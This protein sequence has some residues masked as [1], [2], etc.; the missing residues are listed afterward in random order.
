MSV[1]SKTMTVFVRA[2]IQN[3]AAQMGNV[4]K[5]LK[6]TLGKNG[7]DM[8][9][10]FAEGLGIAAAALGAFG[11]A[12]VKMSADFA[13]TKKA[14]NVLL[15]SSDKA[16]KHLEDLTQFAAQTPFE[17]KGLTEASKKMLAFKFDVEDVIPI[18]SAVGDAAA[19]L[20]SGQEGIDGM[21]MALSQMKAKGR[22]QGEE[23]LQLAERGVN[24]YQ[25][26]ADY[27]GTDIPGVMDKMRKG[28]VDSTTAIN[29]VVL[30]MQKDF[31][32]GMKGL[33]EEINGMVSN[34]KDGTESVMRDIGKSITEGLNIKEHLK[35]TTEVISGFA[36]AV[37]KLGIREAI[38]QMV[39]PEAIVLIGSLGAVIVTIAVPALVALAAKAL[40]A[41]LAIGGISAPV[42][43]AAAV[44][45]GAF[46]LIMATTDELGN[47]WFNTWEWMK[48]TTSTF[49]DAI[50][51]SIWNFAKDMLEYLKPIMEFF[52]MTDT[53]K[54][55]TAAVSQGVK[56]SS[57]SLNQS[58]LK[59]A[60]DSIGMDKAWAD[61][62]DKL[63]GS[64]DKIKSFNVGNSLDSTFTGLKG[65]GAD[66]EQKTLTK[67]IAKDVSKIATTTNNG[68]IAV[69]KMRALQG[70]ISY[71]AQD[72]T[73]C[74]R[75]IGMALEG[76]P[77]E[78][79]IDVDVARAIAEKEGLWRDSSY[80]AQAGDIAI[81]NDGWH[82]TMVT[83][84]GG[85]IQ[86]G[87]SHNGVWESSQSPEDMFGGVTG[88]IATSSYFT[89]ARES[90]DN[91]RA[92]TLEWEET[93]NRIN[94]SAQDLAL[95]LT[96]RNKLLGLEGVRKDYQE[97]LLE[98]DKY[99]VEL[100]RKYRDMALKFAKAS[101]PE[102]GAMMS[103]W[104]ENGIA[105]EETEKGKVSFSQ[106]IASELVLIEAE[107]QEKIK[108]LNMA[109]KLFEDDLAKARKETDLAM[110]QEVLSSEQ[111]LTELRKENARSFIDQYYDL[112]KE[113]H[114]TFSDSF[115]SGV[116]D[117]A[118]SFADFF[119]GV[120]TGSSSL[121]ESFAD[122]LSSF[123]SMVAE[124][125]AKWAAARVTMGMFQSIM[126]QNNSLLGSIISVSGG[127]LN[128][129]GGLD[130]YV[131]AGPSISIGAAAGG[132]VVSGLTLVGEEG[133]EL[134]KFNSLSRVFNNKDTKAMMGGSSINMYVSTPDAESF[135]Q[136]RA[137]ISSSLAGMVARGRRNT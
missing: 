69:D 56:L 102:Q 114:T 41:V 15:G 119:K 58:A 13:A 62:K 103:A 65:T 5:T 68:K 22:A 131:S 70:K 3:F 99:A 1:A 106:Q 108:S 71:Y 127:G 48:S 90:I 43:L 6:K 25:Y 107:K 137:Q 74:M 87:E 125:V 85:T 52:G 94:D 120:I 135:K 118:D 83:E 4:E 7:Y 31:K 78:G 76:T 93:L 27:L 20:G 17:L 49:V 86:N 91:L 14:F 47:L 128:L 129:T 61:T 44:I 80:K 67:G 109:T 133:P 111:A 16:Q 64:L 35:E 23:M 115:K 122:L 33:S 117:V 79:V 8:S 10:K 42:I 100:E 40:A 81:V 39:P 113:A 136:S 130:S 98:T 73:N 77:F 124:M 12:V 54:N 30:G 57:Q 97:L 29:A 105:F 116:G 134:V 24:A 46:A 121:K 96:E 19:M 51:L 101:V 9:R 132:G 112:W 45:G 89:G 104:T 55:W 72:G 60:A 59:N 66:S 50:S 75:T 92:K 26:L 38:L 2:N 63:S 53:I 88:Y 11:V 34:I 123:I 18:L 126:P 36:A 84:N 82:A 95:D 32:G 37:K 28:A 110:M 21:L